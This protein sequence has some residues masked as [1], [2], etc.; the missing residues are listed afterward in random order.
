VI[1]ANVQHTALYH[2]RHSTC[3]LTRIHPLASDGY[4]VSHQPGVR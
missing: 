4:A 3:S 1:V 2:A